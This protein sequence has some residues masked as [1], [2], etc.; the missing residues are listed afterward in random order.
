MQKITT[1]L[2]FDDQAAEEGLPGEVLKK[3]FSILF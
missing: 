2:R 3:S 1:Y